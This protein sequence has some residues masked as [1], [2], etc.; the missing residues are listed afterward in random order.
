MTASTSRADARRSR[1][2]LLQAG[3]AAF[4]DVWKQYLALT[5][6]GLRPAAATP[7]PAGPPRLPR[8]RV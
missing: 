3:A 2:L 8:A 1:R 5:L 4:P 7:L 6:D